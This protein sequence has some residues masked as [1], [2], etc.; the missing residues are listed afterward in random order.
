VLVKIRELLAAVPS[1]S[2]SL[3]VILQS[4]LCAFSPHKAELT[5]NPAKSARGPEVVVHYAPAP[6]SVAGPAWHA[7]LAD[8]VNEWLMRTGQIASA[9][10]DA[11]HQGA[12][13]R[14]A[15]AFPRVARKRKLDVFLRRHDHPY[16]APFRAV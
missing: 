3:S 14:V 6:P 1:S 10:C 7:G 13:P 12:F 2:A 11:G 16:R 8:L 5:G 9:P 4:L 15:R